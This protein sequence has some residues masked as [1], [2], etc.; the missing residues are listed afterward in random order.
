MKLK[1]RMGSRVL[2]LT[3]K[4]ENQEFE[5]EFRFHVKNR[6]DLVAIW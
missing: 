5:W 4:S 2:P 6:R 3:E 1:P